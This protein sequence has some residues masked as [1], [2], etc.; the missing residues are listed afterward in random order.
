FVSNVIVAIY[1]GCLTFT[2]QNV[3]AKQIRR[4]PKI[5]GV[6]EVLAVGLGFLAGECAYRAGRTLL[7]IY[8]SD[9]QVIEAGMIKLGTVTRF[10]FLYG[11]ME[12]IV[13]SLRGMGA[14]IVPMIVSLMGVC[15]FRIFWIMTVFQ[16]YHTIEILFYSYPISWLL[17]GAIHFITWIF[18]MRKMI[19][20]QEENN[21]QR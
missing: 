11:M 4:V 1:Q 13:G 18:V 14:S 19:K 8:A 20:K 21:I 7:S 16:A 9:P 15:V 12:V 5:L 17:T 3:G 2:S 6:C 10:Y